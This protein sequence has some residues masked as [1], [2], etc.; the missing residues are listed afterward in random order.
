MIKKLLV[1]TFAIAIVSVPAAMAA[2]TGPG[3]GLGKVLFEG[4]KGMFPQT[5]AWTTNG[6]TGN[7]TF[8]LTS[9][10]LGCDA[11]SV[12]LKEKEQETFVST[13]LDVLSEEMAQG[14][15]QYVEAM[16]GLMGCS[17]DVYADFG[18]MS[19]TR[20]EILFNSVDADT[21]SL[22]TA[23]KREISTNPVLA[24]SCSRVS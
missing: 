2:D 21:Q 13:N 24:S 7:Q 15:G 5:L 10:T 16:A 20:Y 18:K 8:G 6:S 3:C 22:L 4:E 12:I 17:Q 11:D 23:I 14:K 9:G 1:L 19:Q